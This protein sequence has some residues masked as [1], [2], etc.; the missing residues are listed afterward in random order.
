MEGLCVCLFVACLSP[1]CQ[2]VSDVNVYN[3]Y[4]R[5]LFHTFFNRM[6]RERST[7]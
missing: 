1:T 5:D 7:Q 3:M 4:K 2:Y 6:W